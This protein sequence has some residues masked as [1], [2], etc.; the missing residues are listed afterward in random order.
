MKR[1]TTK[2]ALLGAALAGL[3]AAPASA[4]LNYY[5]DISALGIGGPA[6]TVSNDLSIITDNGG[7][8]AVLL[9]ELTQG[10]FYNPNA[11]NVPPA[12]ASADSY[13]GGGYN[14]GNS[15]TTPS[16]IL[17]GKA[18]DLGGDP[19]AEGISATL[20]NE[21]WIPDLDQ[22]TASSTP[23]PTGTVNAPAF[24]GRFSASS[25]AMGTYQIRLNN[26]NGDLVEVL[27]G[28]ITNGRFSQ[29]LT[30]DANLDGDV[31]IF[32][33]NG[34]GDVQI[35][36]SN[37]GTSGAGVGLLQ[38]DL[39][40]DDDVDVFQGNGQG[41]IQIILANLGATTGA[42]RGNSAGATYDFQTGELTFDIIGSDVT[43]IGL[44]STGNIMIAEA[45]EAG[46]L[47]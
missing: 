30:G 21:T 15:A 18:V 39:N 29:R 4:D 12:S 36:L 33:G 1:F 24:G 13:F 5:W 22:L 8:T 16:P 25:D 11:S 41:D 38:G 9:A 31:D 43:V 37:L 28:T 47:S 45:S 32:Q 19:L 26:E 2:N 3:A 23:F 35:V 6:G 14:T 40:G 44:E 34:Q 17:V 27:T 42:T 7:F 20:I 10:T 46:T